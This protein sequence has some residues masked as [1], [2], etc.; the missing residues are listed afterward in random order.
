M[1]A[2]A[3][4][5]LRVLEISHQAGAVCGRVLADLGAEVVKL[6]PPG[7]EP[8]RSIV[9]RIP[10]AGGGETSAFWLAFNLN[11]TSTC[12]ALDTDEG[13][14]QFRAMAKEADIVVTDWERCPV[15]EMDRLAAAAR[16]ANPALIWVE[17]LPFGRGGPYEG[18]PATDTVLQA[19]GGHLYLNGDI[20]RPPVRISAPVGLVQG[21]AEAA[22]AALMA[23][24]HRLRTGEGQ[25]VDVSIQACIVWTLLNSTMIAQILGFNESRGGAIRRERANRFYTRLV[26]ETRDG[27]VYFGPVGGGGGAAREKSYANLLKWMREDGFDDAILTAHD[28]NGDGQFLIPQAEYDAVTAVIERFIATKATDELMARA[29]AER[30]LLAPV[31]SI[32]DVFANPHFRARGLYQPL[33]DAARDLAVEVPSR[34][35]RLSRTPLAAPRPAPAVPTL[36]TAR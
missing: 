31:S 15:A 12:V 10:T 34:W 26:W 32:A 18:Y 35:A 24:Y 29:V 14:A 30:I 2:G 13:L 23:Y 8:A 22:S 21:G 28:W 27:F 3:L 36:E 19:L 1:T 11:K 25:R 5:G 16:A 7:G 17:I 9:P 4:A 33:D 6:E 20:D